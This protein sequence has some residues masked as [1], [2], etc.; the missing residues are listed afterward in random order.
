MVGRRE[1]SGVRIPAGAGSRARTPAGACHQQVSGVTVSGVTVMRSTPGAQTRGPRR[2]SLRRRPEVGERLAPVGDARQDVESD[3]TT[4]CDI[5][6]KIRSMVAKA[7]TVDPVD[8]VEAIETRDPVEAIETHDGVDPVETHDGVG[9]SQ[10][11]R[12]CQT[13]RLHSGALISGLR[14]VS[15]RG[16][17]ATGL[18]RNVELRSILRSATEGMALPAGRQYLCRK[19]HPV[20]PRT[21]WSQTRAALSSVAGRSGKAAG[22]RRIL[23]AFRKPTCS[24]PA[25]APPGA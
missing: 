24:G 14:P 16:R 3:G 17:T 12:R 13:C 5:Y 19:R 11:V 22:G 8:P 23:Q 15:V 7:L 25:A 2:G 20:L 9:T 6:D 4:V 18:V 10:S 21:S 1:A